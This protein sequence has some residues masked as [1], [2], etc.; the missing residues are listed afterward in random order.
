VCVL[1]TFVVA[2]MSTPDVGNTV[3]KI[4]KQDPRTAEAEAKFSKMTKVAQ[5]QANRVALQPVLKSKYK[6]CRTNLD[7]QADQQ[8]VDYK[9][10]LKTLTGDDYKTFGTIFNQIDA[11]KKEVQDCRCPNCSGQHPD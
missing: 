11:G 2:C 6:Q 3:S 1:L 7:C 10:I 8:C 4:L 9:E 5:I